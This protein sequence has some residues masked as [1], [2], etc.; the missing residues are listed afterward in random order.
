MNKNIFNA[1][2]LI[3]WLM[4]IVGVGLWSVPAALVVG[5]IILMWVTLML[6]FRV[7]VRAEKMKAQE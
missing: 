1:S 5:G 6:V 2:L 4:I 3:G 7:G